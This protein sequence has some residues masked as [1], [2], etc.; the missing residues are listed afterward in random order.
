[1]E[2]ND[3]HAISN[4]CCHKEEFG[5]IIK[6]WLSGSQ[7]APCHLEFPNEDVSKEVVEWITRRYFSFKI[8]NC[9]C[10]E[11]ILSIGTFSYILYYQWT[12]FRIC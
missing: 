8:Q 4:A 11:Y 5:T 1:M 6:M 12:L 2:R 10:E 9:P 3:F 7:I